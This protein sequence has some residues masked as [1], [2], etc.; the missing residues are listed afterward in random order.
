MLTEINERKL[1]ENNIIFYNIIEC[2]ST[3]R[4]ERLQYDQEKIQEII[5]ECNVELETHEFQKSVRL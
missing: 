2:E 1:R 5:E 3:S 4:D